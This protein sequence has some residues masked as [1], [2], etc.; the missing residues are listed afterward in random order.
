MP[1]TQQHIAARSDT[2][3]IERFTAK[4]EMMGLDTPGTFVHDNMVKLIQV[5]VS[6]GKTITDVHAY[7]AQHRREYI[8]ATPAPAGADPAAVI[9]DYLEAAIIAVRGETPA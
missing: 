1:T 3:L 6:E 9:D 4:A 2:D 7:A 8:D 5:P